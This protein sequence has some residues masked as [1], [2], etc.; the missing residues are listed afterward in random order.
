MRVVVESNICMGSGNC[1]AECPEVFA[2][3][4]AG[5]VVLLDETPPEEMRERVE[6]AAAECPSQCISV[7]R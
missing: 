2:Q 4:D 7:E 6:Q 3:D 1:V 5:V